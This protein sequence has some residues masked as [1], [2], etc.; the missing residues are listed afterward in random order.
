MTPQIEIVPT[1]CCSEIAPDEWVGALGPVGQV[2]FN[3]H[4]HASRQRS[5]TGILHGLPE[6]CGRCQRRVMTETPQLVVS[7]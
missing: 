6:I 2:G 5:M 4:G 3:R 7:P 1:G